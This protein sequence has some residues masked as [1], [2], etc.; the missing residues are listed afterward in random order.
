MADAFKQIR[1]SPDSASKRE[2]MNAFDQIALNPRP[3]ERQRASKEG[4]ISKI[5]NLDRS[6]RKSLSE[7][8]ADPAVP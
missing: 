7:L 5:R 3:K 4:K 1:A 6:N 8:I 2:L